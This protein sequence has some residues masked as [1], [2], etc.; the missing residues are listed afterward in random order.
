MSTQLEFRSLNELPWQVKIGAGVG[1][2]IGSSLCAYWDYKYHRN[3]YNHKWLESYL[4]FLGISTIGGCLGA[5]LGPVAILFWPL[6][7]CA[8][9]VSA[10]GVSAQRI[11]QK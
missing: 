3:V 9:I 6:P 10:I 1:M 11:N 2:T 8:A 7:C 4:N 5:I